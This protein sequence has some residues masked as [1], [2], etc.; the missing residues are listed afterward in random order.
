MFSVK[1]V[2]KTLVTRSAGTK[3]STGRE[4]RIPGFLMAMAVNRAG[5]ESGATAPTRTR[6]R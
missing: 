3:V 4:R 1:Q 2:G 6:R 5:D